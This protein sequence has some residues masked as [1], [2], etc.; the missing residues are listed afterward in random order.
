MIINL[1]RNENKGAQ[2]KYRGETWR[3]SRMKELRT[4]DLKLGRQPRE[5]PKTAE[6]GRRQW[7][8]YASQGAK[9]IKSSKYEGKNK[10]THTHTTLQ[11]L[12]TGNRIKHTHTHTHTIWLSLNIGGPEH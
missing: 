5:P 7:R 6:S 4:A 2:K 11:Q 1:Q 10:K 9:R 8:P 12:K 3:R